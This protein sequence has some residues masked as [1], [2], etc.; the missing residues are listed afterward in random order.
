M[1]NLFKSNPR[2]LIP[3]GHIDIPLTS[4]T[5]YI[6]DVLSRTAFTRALRL[7]TEIITAPHPACL[8]QYAWKIVT[9]DWTAKN[10]VRFPFQL[11]VLMDDQF[12]RL[13]NLTIYWHLKTITFWLKCLINAPIQLYSAFRFTGCWLR[14]IRNIYHKNFNEYVK[15]KR[16]RAACFN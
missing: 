16:E 3:D 5:R 13:F 12:V 4:F 15:I 11:R 1:F 2:D 14:H 6:D 8:G 10:N 7:V 9:N